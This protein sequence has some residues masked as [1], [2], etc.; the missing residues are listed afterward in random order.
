MRVVDE[1]VEA[2]HC[3]D[4]DILVNNAA[5]QYKKDSVQDISPQ[6]LER[7]FRTNTFSHFFMVRYLCI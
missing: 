5:V 3:I 6:Q 7:V 4:I 2:Y 1:V